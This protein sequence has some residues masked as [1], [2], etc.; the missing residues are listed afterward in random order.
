MILFVSFECF[1]VCKGRGGQ[2]RQKLPT[3]K[4]KGNK[5]NNMQTFDSSKCISRFHDS[6]EHEYQ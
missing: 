1:G 4:F 6:T 3:D 5:S 2:C